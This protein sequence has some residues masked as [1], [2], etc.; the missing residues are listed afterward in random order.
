VDCA[1]LSQRMGRVRALQGKEATESDT[2]TCTR[3]VLMTISLAEPQLAGCSLDFYAFI[4]YIY[5]DT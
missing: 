5:I 3:A 2:L 1:D 4:L